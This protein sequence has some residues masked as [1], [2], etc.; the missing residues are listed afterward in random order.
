VQDTGNVLL[1]RSGTYLS[2]FFIQGNGNSAGN[3]A[4]VALE[5]EQGVTVVSNIILLADSAMGGFLGTVTVSGRIIGTNGMETLTMANRRANSQSYVLQL[6]S[7]SGPNV[8]GNT[9]IDPG[10]NL[11]QLIRVQAMANRAISTN[12]LSIGAHGVFAL[13]GFSHTVA[14]LQNYP[15]DGAFIPT[16][17]NGATNAATFTVGTDATS[18]EFDGVFLDGGAAS[19]GVTKVGAGTLT[20]TGNSTNTGAVTVGA[21]TLALL[22]DGSFSNAAQIV[23]SSDAVLDV[24]ARTDGNLNLQNGQTLK[25]NGGING[26]LA[27]LPG[28]IVNPG[29]SIGTLTVS[30]NATLAGTLRMEVNRSSV[31][32]C[33]QFIVLGTL[34]AG[35]TL[36]VTNIGAALQVNDIFQLFPNGISGFTVSLPAVDPV[37]GVTYTWQDKVATDGF[38]KVLSVTPLAPPTLNVSK[39]GNALTFS[40]TGPFKLQSQTNSLSNGL[41]NNWSDYPG[42]GSSPVNLTINPTNPAVYFR[43]SQ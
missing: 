33:D 24:T 19:L 43:L 5:M 18:T 28:S 8:W 30:N 27:T 22:T 40:W 16:V 13:N 1:D 29:S 39:T 34:T 37:N 42:G 11:N 3:I 10:D 15:I 23:I 41:R 25:G 14:N 32:N 2:T 38:V 9:V 36:A 7:Q 6:G 12:G 17:L 20:L 26:N 21:G 31:P 35:G 4:S